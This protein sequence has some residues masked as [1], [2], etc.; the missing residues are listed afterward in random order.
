MSTETAVFIGRR[1]PELLT[2]IVSPSTVTVKGMGFFRGVGCRLRRAALLADVILLLLLVP[3]DVQAGNFRIA[4]R[5]FERAV[6]GGKQ[7]G[8]HWRI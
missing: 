7:Q 8:C 6:F 4:E 5:Q 1:G 2:S 3:I